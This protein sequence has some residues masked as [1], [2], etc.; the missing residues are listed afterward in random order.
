MLLD[1][2][3][4]R[5]MCHVTHIKKAK[6]HFSKSRLFTRNKNS[7][8]P[9]WAHQKSH[10]RG[11]HL[12]LNLVVS[13]LKSVPVAP[14]CLWGSCESVGD[15]GGPLYTAF[16]LSRSWPPWN[17]LRLEV[18]RGKR[19]RSSEGAAVAPGGVL[20][21]MLCAEGEAVGVC[22]PPAVLQN[23]GEEM[24]KAK[25]VHSRKWL[26]GYKTNQQQSNGK[27]SPAFYIRV[28]RRNSV[29]LAITEKR[30]TSLILNI[31][32]T[33]ECKRKIKWRVK[34]VHEKRPS[35][36]VLNYL[37]SKGSHLRFASSNS[38]LMSALFIISSARSTSNNA[39]IFYFK[40]VHVSVLLLSMFIEPLNPFSLI[41]SP[42][43]TLPIP[44]IFHPRHL[45]F[46]HKQVKNRHKM[47]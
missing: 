18:P 7:A 13:L 22:F 2:L 21:L 42:S 16:F 45:S 34:I 37:Q 33:N 15:P 11:S 26:Q 36:G 31:I 23:R 10:Q 25:Q 14:R 9:Q 41:C 44:S 27:P 28:I 47:L 4:S 43:L 8:R 17:V 40:L 12:R 20:V 32:F 5:A 19:I 46:K 6:Q 1:F 39:F 35:F 24:R 30:H 3:Y 38:H 29:S